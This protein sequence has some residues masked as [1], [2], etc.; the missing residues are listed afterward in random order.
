MTAYST[1][2]SFPAAE[3]S[4]GNL[5]F[6][7]S[8]DGT[9]QPGIYKSDGATWSNTNTGKVRG[10][11]ALTVDRDILPTD[12]DKFLYT[13]E[14]TDVNF[15]IVQDSTLDLPINSELVLGNRNT[16]ALTV[17]EGV[18]VTVVSVGGLLSVNPEG[19]GA[20]LIKIA[21][22]TWWLFGDLV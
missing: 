19:A 11:V 9:S 16:G 21:A 10:V 12:V 4:N 6:L 22:D 5:V 7:D 13:N 17:V 15:T 2:A 14:V 18:G 3:I 1:V 8:V 20:S